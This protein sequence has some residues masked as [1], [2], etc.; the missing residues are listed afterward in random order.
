MIRK[1]VP[2]QCKHHAGYEKGMVI[3]MP[4][5]I[6]HYLFGRDSYKKLPSGALKDN[7]LKNHAAYTLGQQG[8]DLFFYFFPSYCIHGNNIGAIS[9]CN[10]TNAF[11]RGLLL[12]CHRFRGRDLQ[13]AIAYLTGFIGHYTLD[14]NC[15]PYVYARTGFVKRTGDYFSR[16]AYLETDID[17]KLL[18][19]KLHRKPV[20]FHCANTIAVTPRQSR[21]IARML[22][23]ACHYAFP[24]LVFHTYM[25]RAAIFSMHF[26]LK[27]LHDN[28]GQKKVFFR[29]I[30]KHVLGYPIFSPLVPSNKL[31]FCSDPFNLARKEWKNPWDHTLVSNETFFD[32]YQK[33]EASYSSRLKKLT[34]FFY[35]PATPQKRMAQMKDLIQDYDNLSFH[36]GLDCSIPS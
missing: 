17:K 6:T 32:L 15:H 25:M 16:H 31:W 34:C 14:T 10:E 23:D 26:G 24:K 18:Y 12:S 1:F 27:L 2:A 29:F 19:R 20:N 22:Y 3:F 36:S 33:A 9:H 28:N 4:G 30:E 21:V 8:P 35:E 13:I 5:F 11:F 7:I